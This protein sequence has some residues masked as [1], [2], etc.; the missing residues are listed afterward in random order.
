MIQAD[1]SSKLQVIGRTRTSFAVESGG[2]ASNPGFSSTTGV[3]ISLKRLNQV[4]LSGDK[5]TV[6]IG[7]S[8]VSQ[9]ELSLD[10]LPLSRTNDRHGLKYT[11]YWMAQASMSLADERPG[12]A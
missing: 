2:H 7:M 1:I 11:K 3:H 12:L 9:A 6:T 8:Q 5:S 10:E 4:S